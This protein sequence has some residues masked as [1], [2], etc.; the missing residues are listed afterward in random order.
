ML[1]TTV[2]VNAGIT[3]RSAS[4]A[5]YLACLIVGLG[6]LFVGVT[7]PLLSAFVP[8]LVRDALGDHRTAI[9]FVMAIDNFLLLLLVPWTGAASDRAR[10]SGRGRMPLIIP[11]F[12]SLPSAWWSFPLPLASAS[13]D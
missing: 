9:G 2:E 10:A 11:A 13:S 1:N 7:G 8:P 6:G 12:S 4:A 5:P 3:A